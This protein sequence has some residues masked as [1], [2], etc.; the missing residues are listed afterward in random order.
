MSKYLLSSDEEMGRLQLQARVWEAEAVNMLDCIGVQPGWSCVDLGCGAMGILGSLSRRVGSEGRVIGV[1]RETPLIEAAQRYI[2]EE[3]LRNVELIDAD[4]HHS[5]LPA[6]TFDLVH[7]R[8]VLPYVDVETV[9]G[10]MVSL[11]RPG[12]IVAVQEP[13]HYSWNYFPESPRWPRFREI[14][15][16]TFRL[17]GDIN[18][19]RQTFTVLR[20]T[21]LEDVTVRAAVIA[22]QD[23]HPYMRLPIIALGALR[24]TILEAGLA[25]E[26]ELEDC[27]ADLEARVSDPG[28]FAVMFTTTQVW[29]RK[30]L[31]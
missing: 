2:Q 11:T 15:E 17:K 28:T 23:S 10:E 16:A 26:A 22:L 7:E 6:G 21:G 19:G 8:F 25:T 14:L 1:D 3:S 31:A 9:I 29:G 4:V 13:D 27:V 24:P 5:G 12:G 30:P 20:S 18:V